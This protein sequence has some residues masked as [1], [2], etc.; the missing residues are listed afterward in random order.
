MKDE[1]TK[2]A[3]VRLRAEGKSYT[4]IAAEL[5]IS[6]S[7]CTAWERELQAEITKAQQITRDELTTAYRM[8]AEARVK[9]LGETLDSI[10]AA[11]A[12]KD[13]T[14]LPADKLLALKLKYTSAL[15]TASICQENE[16]MFRS[17]GASL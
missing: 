4:A 1:A 15:A 8:T 11:L 2:R 9:E 7:T 10:N 14:Q 5:N 13:L 17:P 12:Q 16:A 3:F 6:K